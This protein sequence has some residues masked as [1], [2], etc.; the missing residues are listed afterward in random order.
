MPA[1]FS[2]GMLLPVVTQLLLQWM[3]KEL[4]LPRE[5][6]VFV[7]FAISTRL[8][9]LSVLVQG[10]AATL[11]CL[12]AVRDSF[13]ADSAVGPNR[14]RTGFSGYPFACNRY[15]SPSVVG[16]KTKNRPPG[17]GETGVLSG[18]IPI[19]CNK[20]VALWQGRISNCRRK[21]IRTVRRLRISNVMTVRF[22]GV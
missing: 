13:P 12:T 21:L 15:S 18:S 10:K 6:G 3:D 16:E 5:P 20:S 22:T 17:E 7:L 1:V 19:H 14:P 9:N 11:A 2:S 4:A 8:Y